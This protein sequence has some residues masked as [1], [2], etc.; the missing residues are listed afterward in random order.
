MAH[1]GT[2]GEGPWPLG[3]GGERDRG[4]ATFEDFFGTEH[5]RLFGALCFVTGDRAAVANRDVA[6]LVW[7]TKGS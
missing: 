3:F 6:S 5:A 7:R 4:T 2:L 1:D